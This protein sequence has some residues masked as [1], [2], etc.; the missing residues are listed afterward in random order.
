MRSVL[1][2]RCHPKMSPSSSTSTGLQIAI[3]RRSLTWTTAWH[4]HSAAI[5]YHRR[6]RRFS[7]NHRRFLSE[8]GSARY[9]STPSLTTVWSN[10]QTLYNDFFEVYITKTVTLSPMFSDQ[11]IS[12]DTN[13]VTS[14]SSFLLVNRLTA[15]VYR[16][17]DH[18]YVNVHRH[19][20]FIFSEINNG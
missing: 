11:F 16:Y 12:Q 17:D 15:D 10:Y 9:S 18:K 13:H 4:E 2:I 8:P 7:S 1:L 14:H 20:L 5:F 3:R 6:R 19:Q